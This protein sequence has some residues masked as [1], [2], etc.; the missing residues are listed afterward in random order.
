MNVRNV[1]VFPAGTEVG[2]EIHQALKYCKEV[3]LH[4]AGQGISNHAPYVYRSFHTIPSIHEPDWL[5]ALVELCQKLDIDYIFP[6]YDDIIVALT[7][8]Q[9]KIPATVLT[10][11]YEVCELTR[12]K[13]QTYKFLAQVVRVPKLY[14]KVKSE[15][16]PIFVKPD[17]GQG[18]QGAQI[19]RNQRELT[20]ALEAVENPLIC[21]YLPGEEYTIDCFSDRDSGVLFCGAR[22]R[23]RTRN[24]I[25]VH[26]QSVEIQGVNKIA[27]QI[28]NAL[29]LRGAWFFQLK[30]SSNGELV[31]LEV[32]PRIAGSMSTHRVQG[33]NFPLLTIFEHER[34]PIELMNHSMCVELDR[35]LHNRYKL[36]I[37]YE[38]LYIDLDDTL[39]LRGEVNLDALQLVYQCSN[40]NIKII[41]STRHTGNLYFT[42]KRYRLLELFDEII[43]LNGGQ[44]KSDF[45][46]HEN[47]IFVD[48]SFTERK[49]V[50]LNCGIM[51]FDCSMIEAL[52]NSVQSKKKS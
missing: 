36:E 6:A 42:L 12:S 10:A 30:R 16:F 14:S 45:I 20:A 52:I 48:D 17:R 34:L 11:S 51:T 26:T 15:L 18:S 40:K 43:H 22:V 33:V 46:R 50:S 47:A 28:H 24:G 35:A 8:Y 21:E 31:L 27:E 7:Q 1:L 44:L 4:G 38:A 2:L 39:L 29:K 37:N 5:N 41:L 19:A 49:D 13:S 9:D 32:A 25:A 3:V 23:L